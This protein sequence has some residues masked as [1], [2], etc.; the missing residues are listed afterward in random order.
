MV[1]CGS[2][3][4]EIERLPIG[5]LSGLV[6]EYCWLS[7][8]SRE[9]A[10]V[11]ACDTG[12]AGALVELH[13]ALEVVHLTAGRWYYVLLGG[14]ATSRLRPSWTC[15]SV[16]CLIAVP[17]SLTHSLSL[18]TAFLPIVTLHIPSAVEARLDPLWNQLLTKVPMFFRALVFFYAVDWMRNSDYLLLVTTWAHFTLNESI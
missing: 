16:V 8:M 5:I 11:K 6:S 7:D 18:P 12:S 10:A 9:N 1:F 14:L 2:I 3:L 4:S 15:S 13:I 17:P